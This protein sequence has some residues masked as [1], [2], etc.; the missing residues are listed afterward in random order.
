ME[1]SDY[2]DYTTERH[3]FPRYDPRKDG[4][5]RSFH[6]LSCR[7][8]CLGAVQSAE[9]SVFLQIICGNFPLF[10]EFLSKSKNK[11]RNYLQLFIR[12]AYEVLIHENNGD[13]EISCYS[14]SSVSQFSVFLRL[15]RPLDLFIFTSHYFLFDQPNSDLQKKQFCFK[16][17]FLL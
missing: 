6:G 3:A 16:L 15:E 13:L 10:H 7:K 17:I 5:V 14:P 9:S 11:I 12:G 8:A 2:S 1:N 4:K